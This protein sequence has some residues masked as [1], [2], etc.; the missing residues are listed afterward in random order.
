MEGVFYQDV[1]FQQ[2]LTPFY[3]KSLDV[4]ENILQ[5]WKKESSIISEL[6]ILSNVSKIESKITRL[7]EKWK[8]RSYSSISSWENTPVKPGELIEG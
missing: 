8:L 7:E 2:T 6:G 4:I 1:T 5:I 3:P